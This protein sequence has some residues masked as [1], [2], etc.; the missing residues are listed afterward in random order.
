L[1]NSI[2]NGNWTEVI[3]PKG[4]LLDLK[5]KNLWQYRDLIILLVKRDFVAVYKQTILGPLWHFIQPLMTTI[6]FTIVF[7]RIAK[8]PTDGLPP[9]LFYMCGIVCWNYFSGCLTKT[10]STF[11]FACV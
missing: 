4:N 7:T 3:E 5:V 1:N 8:I 10:S 11:V 9:I 6:T 2:D